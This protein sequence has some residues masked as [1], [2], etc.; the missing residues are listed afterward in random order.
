MTRDSIMIIKVTKIF[1]QIT[2]NAQFE[3]ILF[4]TFWFCFIE[5]I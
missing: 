2:A 1:E 4:P 3:N 5:P